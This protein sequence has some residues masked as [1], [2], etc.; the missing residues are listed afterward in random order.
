MKLRK[1]TQ[2]SIKAIRILHKENGRLLQAK[3]IAEGENIPVKFLYPI[4]RK[5]S[6][7]KLVIIE[8]GI[9]GGYIATKKL[10]SF[11]LYDLL[12]L[13]EGDISL[14]FCTSGE[15]CNVSDVFAQIDNGIKI[16]LRN[17]K[18]IDIL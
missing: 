5:L 10:D 2:Y 15:N 14:N 9:N 17:I 12:V 16:A 13:M 8:R 6:K 7:E 4:L 3:E 18:L 1:E 11:T